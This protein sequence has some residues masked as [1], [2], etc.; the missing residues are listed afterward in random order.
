MGLR[1]RMVTRYRDAKGRSRLVRDRPSGIM[2]ARAAMPG[3][4]PEGPK[5][6]DSPGR[7]SGLYSDA[8]WGPD[9]AAYAAASF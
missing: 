1:R 4:V 2:F 3:R 9:N 6:N 8:S 5:M 7:E